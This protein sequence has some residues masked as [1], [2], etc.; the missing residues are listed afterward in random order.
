MQ[1]ILEL[2]RVCEALNAINRI[3]IFQLGVH[4]KTIEDKVIHLSLS[5]PPA[6]YQYQN[7]RF[8]EVPLHP[9]DYCLP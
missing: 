2:A 5:L 6:A 7:Q 3:T 1:S 4:D 9:P 8:Y